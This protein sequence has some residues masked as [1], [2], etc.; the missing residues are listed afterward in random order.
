MTSDEFDFETWSST[1]MILVLDSTGV[2][3][4]PESVRTD[5]EDGCD[6]HDVADRITAEYGDDA[7]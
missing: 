4:D 2:E 6:V 3:L 5:Y 7:H 1:L